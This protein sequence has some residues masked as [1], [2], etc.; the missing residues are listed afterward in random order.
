VDLTPKSVLDLLTSF[1]PGFKC[2]GRDLY[3]PVLQ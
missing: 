2:K 1:D 3:D